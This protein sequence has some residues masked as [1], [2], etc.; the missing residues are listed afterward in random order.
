VNSASDAAS[1]VATGKD[2]GADLSVLG[3]LTSGAGGN[4]FYPSL[5]ITTTSLSGN[6]N[7]PMQG[8][9]AASAGASPYKGWW[10]ETT[11]GLCGGN[12]GTLPPGIV[13]GRGGTVNG[14]FLALTVALTSN[15]AKITLKQTIIAGANSWTPGQKVQLAGFCIDPANPCGGDSINDAVFNGTWLVVASGANCTNTV[16]IVCLAVTS[17][18][19]V[20]HAV[21]KKGLNNPTVTFAPTIAGTFTWWMGVRDGAFQ[22]ARGAV[23]LTVGN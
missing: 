23:T 14:P 3:Q 18:D 8:V 22:S 2:P 11:A 17:A 7:V 21:Y 12:C 13:I 20:S 1:R 4:V 10:L 9:L 15:V 6:A 5:S 16:N 19:I